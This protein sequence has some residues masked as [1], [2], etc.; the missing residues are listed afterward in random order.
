MI[1]PATSVPR[2][3]RRS[4]AQNLF[5]I[6]VNVR[7]VLA[8]SLSIVPDAWVSSRVTSAEVRSRLASRRSSIIVKTLSVIRRR[9]L[10]NHERADVEPRSVIS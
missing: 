3:Q 2:A 4:A 10:H 9:S 7:H 5:G 6:G 8:P 1:S